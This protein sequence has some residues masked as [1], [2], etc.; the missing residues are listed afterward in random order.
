MSVEY[1]CD[2]CGGSDPNFMQAIRTD[3]V[4]MHPTFGNPPP[5]DGHLCGYCHSHLK[6]FMKGMQ[7]DALRGAA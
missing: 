1:V 7:V 3:G 6:V 5:I 2:R 4:V